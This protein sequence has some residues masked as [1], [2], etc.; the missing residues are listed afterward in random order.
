MSYGFGIPERLFPHHF[1]LK[2]RTFTIIDQ[3]AWGFLNRDTGEPAIDYISK[4]R[5]MFGFDHEPSNVF[6][7]Y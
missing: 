3:E 6:S 5:H 2:L 4:L 1:G 7:V